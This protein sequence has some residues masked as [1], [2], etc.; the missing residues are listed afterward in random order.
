MCHLWI[1]PP[2]HCCLCLRESF[3]PLVHIGFYYASQTGFKLPSNPPAA[4]TASRAG[5][6][7]FRIQQ[8]NSF[9]K[10][11]FHQICRP[12]LPE[13]SLNMWS[14]TNKTQHKVPFRMALWPGTASVL[15]QAGLE[16]QGVRGGGAGRASQGFSEHAPG[17]LSPLEQKASSLRCVFSD[18]FISRPFS[19]LILPVVSLPRR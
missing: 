17:V 15:S 19:Q 4:V 9:Q 10:N 6:T 16:G 7:T 5:T 1:S 14:K 12:N 3:E 11:L 13:I 8:L 18:L 2:N